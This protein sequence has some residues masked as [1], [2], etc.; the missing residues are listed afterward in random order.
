MGYHSPPVRMA[1]KDNNPTNLP[2]QLT[3]QPGKKNRINFGENW[4]ILE[5]W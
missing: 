5:C 4:K 2:K 3:K 1:T